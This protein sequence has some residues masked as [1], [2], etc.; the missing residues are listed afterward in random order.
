MKAART[1]P[2]ALKILWHDKVFIKSKNVNEIKVALEGKGYNFTDKNLMMA[3]KAADFLTRKGNK[4]N[5][6]YIQKYPYAE[7]KEDAKGNKGR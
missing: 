4:G 5:Y 6:L 2:G 3:L 1:A 7:E